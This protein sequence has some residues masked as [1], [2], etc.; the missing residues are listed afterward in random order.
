MGRNCCAGTTVPPLSLG[1]LLS[2]YDR[3]VRAQDDL[4][5]FA[6]G[7]WLRIIEQPLDRIDALTNP[8]DLVRYFGESA[9]T[10]MPSPITLYVGQD[11]KNASAYIPYVSQSGLTLLGRDYYQ[12]LRPDPAFVTIRKQFWAYAHGCRV[13][14]ASPIRTLRPTKSLLWITVLPKYSGLPCRS[15]A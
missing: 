4:F 2:G 12:Y 8:A 11:A 5:R 7:Q 3:Q 1:L 13:W 14:P 15:A 10:N 9:Q 6:N